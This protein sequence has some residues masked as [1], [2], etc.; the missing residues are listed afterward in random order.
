[1]GVPADRALLGDPEGMESL[2][3]EL[4][5][6]AESIAGIATSLARQVEQMTFVGPAADQLRSDMDTRRKRAERVA[7][8]LQGAAHS[9][10]KSA[11]TVREQL[12]EL[13]VAEDRRKDSE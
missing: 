12:H 13:R 10:R 6:R 9:L 5:L 4:M 8:E 7:G 3:S 11:S 2:A 1:M